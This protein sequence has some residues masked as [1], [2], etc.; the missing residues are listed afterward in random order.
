MYGKVEICGVNT[1]SLEVLGAGD[2][3]QL[4]LRAKAGDASAREALHLRQSTAGAFRD[5][6]LRRPGARNMDDLL[7]GGLHRPHQGHRQLRRE[8]GTCAFPPTACP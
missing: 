3:R 1:A 2:T 4:L 7:S 5:P 8:P 6:A